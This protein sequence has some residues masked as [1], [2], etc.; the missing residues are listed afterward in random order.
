[1]SVKVWARRSPPTLQ[2]GRPLLWKPDWRP[3]SKLRRTQQSLLGETPKSLPEN[4]TQCSP[5]CFAWEVSPGGWPGAGPGA[6]QPPSPSR[7]DGSWCTAGGTTVSVSGRLAVAAEIVHSRTSSVLENEWKPRAH[8][9]CTYDREPWSGERPQ[10]VG[11]PCSV[12]TQTPGQAA[13][14]QGSKHLPSQAWRLG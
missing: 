2:A 7:K 11:P 4:L 3:L 13:A 6:T 8:R 12:P 1:M 9:L 14:P 5:F 10:A